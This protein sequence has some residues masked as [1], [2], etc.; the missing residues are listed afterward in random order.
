MYYL[1]LGSSSAEQGAYPINPRMPAV[2]AG[3]GA[4]PSAIELREICGLLTHLSR[5]LHQMYGFAPRLVHLDTPDP[6]IRVLVP[7]EMRFPG[8]S[9]AG[10]GRAGCPCQSMIHYHELSRLLWR[11]RPCPRISSGD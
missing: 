6:T 7:P 8:L 1:P 2:G 5:Q 10:P 9:S 11:R 3:V 4:E